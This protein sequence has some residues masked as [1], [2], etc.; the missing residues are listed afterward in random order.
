MIT[1]LLWIILFIVCWPIALLAL[2]LYP[3]VWV[4]L[5]PF[6]ILGFAVDGV[7][8]LIKGIFLLPARMLRSS[9]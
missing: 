8:G 3:I 1:F 5:I 7:L 4:L 2:I 6:R 9:H